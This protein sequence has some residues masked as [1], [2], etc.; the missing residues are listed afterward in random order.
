MIP[1][2]KKQEY[3]KFAEDLAVKAGLLVYEFKSNAQI[4]KFKGKE[5][6]DIAT[7]ADYASEKLII[8]TI[9]KAYPSH[10]VYAEESGLTSQAKS[11]FR[12]II[13]PLDGTKEYVRKIPYYYVILALEY[14][15]D[16]I[17]SAVY[18]PETHY[19]FSSDTQSYLNGS[20]VKV[21]GEK[22]LSRSFISV[23]SPSKSLARSSVH[24]TVLAIKSLVNKSYKIRSTQWDIE[25]LVYVAMGAYEG[26]VS[27]TSPEDSAH[28]K[29]WDVSAGIHM[30]RMAGGVVTDCSGNYKINPSLSNGLIASNGLIHDQ[31]LQTVKSTKL[32]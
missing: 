31:L 32:R 15:G 5:Q 24:K 25:S 8:K 18:Q 13:D 4:E 11:P 16:L 10:A 30:V 29:W 6:L 7:T 28:Y 27:F 3:R 12:W 20:V 14:K 22:D 19:L 1:S 17:A 9:N 23:R 2:K 21:S 26:F